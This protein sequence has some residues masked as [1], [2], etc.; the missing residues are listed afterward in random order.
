MPK[1]GMPFKERSELLTFEEIER[2][3]KA[4]VAAGVSRVRITGGEPLVR[5][6]LPD[7]ATK[8]RHDSTSIPAW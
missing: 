5:K 8:P 2:V 4:F 1:E 7:L 3:V 6:G